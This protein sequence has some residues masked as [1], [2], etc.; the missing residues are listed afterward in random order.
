MPHRAHCRPRHGGGGHPF[1]G[2]PLATSRH[3]ISAVTDDDNPFV[4]A[5]ARDHEAM[6]VAERRTGT[7]WP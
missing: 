3:M 1:H 4:F 7:S 5:A 2:G 6:A